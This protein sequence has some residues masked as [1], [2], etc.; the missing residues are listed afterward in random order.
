MKECQHENLRRYVR[1][2]IGGVTRHDYK[3]SCGYGVSVNLDDFVQV[4]KRD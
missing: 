4:E 3:C 2:S 1:A